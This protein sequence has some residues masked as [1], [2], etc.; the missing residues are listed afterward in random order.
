MVECDICNGSGK[1]DGKCNEC[2][3]GGLILCEACDGTGSVDKID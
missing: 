1:V 2:F 3:G